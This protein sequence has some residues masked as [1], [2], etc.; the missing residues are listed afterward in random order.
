MA[1]RFY[2]DADLLG[3]AKVLVSLRPDVTHPGDPG[4]TGPDGRPRA[5]C[6]ILP[7]AKDTAW[8]PVVAE[9]GWIVISR[10]RHHRSKPSERAAIID[11]SARVVTLDARHQLNKWA[12]LEIIFRQWRAIE[13]V[14]DIPGPWIN[15]ASRTSFKKFDL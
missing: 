3:I 15:T 13:A 6:E 11:S 8:L 5:R 4:G 9:N 10:D 12:Q 1:I 14:T 2:V 7:G